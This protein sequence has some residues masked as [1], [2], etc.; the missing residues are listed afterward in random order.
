MMPG[1]YGNLRFNCLSHKKAFIFIISD[2]I[3]WHLGA[4]KA[5]DGVIDPL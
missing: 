4:A 1:V 2:G 3:L 5:L